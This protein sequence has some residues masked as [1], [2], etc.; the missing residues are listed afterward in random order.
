MLKHRVSDIGAEL[1]SGD[2]GVCGCFERAEAR[3]HDEHGAHE[4]AKGALD[5]R[6]PEHE[7]A[8]AIDDEAGHEGDSVA[9]FADNP[10]CVGQW[11]EEIR[12]K[13][14]PRKASALSLR[15]T[16]CGLEVRV[17]DIQETIGE[18]PE[19]EEDRDKDDG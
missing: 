13:I 6:G 10:P 15:D 5:A 2:E 7:G 14:S 19:E 9:V 12:S 3:A 4:T 1:T 18:A 17:Q 8:D 11:S 16:E